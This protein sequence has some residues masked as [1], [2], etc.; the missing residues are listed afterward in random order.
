M[1][2]RH[3]EG[4]KPGSTLETVIS[5]S[6]EQRRVDTAV[7]EYLR[8]LTKF[9]LP[10]A[11]SADED[12]SGLARIEGIVAERIG[13]VGPLVSSI[14][15]SINSRANTINSREYMNLVAYEEK[16]WRRSGD[17]EF[18]VGVRGCVD[19]G[20]PRE[21]IIGSDGHFGRTLAGDDSITFNPAKGRFVLKPSAFKKRLIHGGRTGK[22]EVLEI[23][24]EHTGC[25]RRGQMLA[26]LGSDNNISRLFGVVMDNMDALVDEF[27][28]QDNPQAINAYLRAS[29]ENWQD[30]SMSQ[31][32]GVWA[33][34]WVKIAQRQ[35][36]GKVADGLNIVSPVQL[37]DKHD[38]N[39]FAG[40]DDI[41]VIGNPISIKSGGF[42]EEALK[43]LA[44]DGDIFSMRHT[45]EQ[46]E[47][48]LS[49][50][51]QITKGESTFQD[52][53]TDWLNTKRKFV[54]VTGKLW[55][56]YQSKDQQFEPV[57]E[58]VT[59]FIDKSFHGKSVTEAMR[60]R[61][62]HQL[63]RAFAYAW[64]LDTFGRGNLP[65]QHIEDHLATGE[66][67]V[68]GVKEHLPL[69]QG[70]LQPPSAAEFFT[71]RS[72]LLHSSPGHAGE[73]IVVMM[74]HDTD[75]PDNQPMST[76][77]TQRATDDTK[78]LLKLWP[79]LV[80]GD[81]VPVVVIRGKNHGGVSRLALSIMLNFGDITDLQASGLLPEFV[82]A[83]TSKG[84]VVMVPALE[85]LS[86]G[87][88]AGRDLK[89]FRAATV[90]IAD[91]YDNSQVQARMP[92]LD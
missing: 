76:E 50:N 73:P 27:E 1:P 83:A 85:V 82:P 55:E 79:Y 88:K 53:Q 46:M 21:A 10:D 68:L 66:S 91:R 51:L 92:Q 3:I 58:M 9:V 67:A 69:G 23:L 24:V 2:E 15:L 48:L 65:G 78:E 20:I 13:A 33:G 59:D 19:A 37:Y 35:A 39:L 25:G 18:E 22:D 5:G 57:R 77:E 43:Q 14:L 34:I 49:V 17:P 80:V 45:V 72:V 40:L 38:G 28:G 84:E 44:E 30:G 47:D 7:G 12:L 63:F 70:D 32:G 52:L 75:R 90:M 41:K 54:T 81:I 87:I 64:T 8:G 4:K 60:R 56:M 42:T 16:Q 71:G 36:Y 6:V 89:T 26:N 29:K 11:L 31:D 74:K 62:T 61:L 86:A